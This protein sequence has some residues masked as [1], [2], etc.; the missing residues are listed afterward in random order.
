MVSWITTRRAWWCDP[1]PLCALLLRER[2]ALQ[3]KSAARLSA[4]SL[5]SK[6]LEMAQ[7]EAVWHSISPLWLQGLG[8]LW[9][10]PI[11]LGYCWTVGPQSFLRKAVYLA[12]ELS[13]LAPAK[14]WA[15]HLQYHRDSPLETIEGKE[16]L[17]ILT[18]CCPQRTSASALC[19]ASL[20]GLLGS[21]DMAKHR[22]PSQWVPSLAGSEMLYCYM[23]GAQSR[24]E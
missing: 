22:V 13:Q 20:P 24:A 2:G 6:A 17:G 1:I 4:S 19:T 21:G 5:P 8:D 14:R 10:I 11:S 3:S 23:S 15:L 16:D 9:K 7:M 18:L 12:T